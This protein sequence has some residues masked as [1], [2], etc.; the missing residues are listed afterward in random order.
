VAKELRYSLE[1]TVSM[2]GTESSTAVFVAVPLRIHP[3]PIKAC[4]KV[5]IISCMSWPLLRSFSFIAS[6]WGNKGKIDSSMVARVIQAA[7]G[8]AP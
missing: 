6:N 2:L 1:N 8:V 7:E 5:L 4:A 3:I